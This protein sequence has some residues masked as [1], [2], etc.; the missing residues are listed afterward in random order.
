MKASIRMRIF[1]PV[2]LIL[3]AFPLAVWTM[4]RYTLD[5]HMNYNAKRDLEVAISR[6][7]KVINE[8]YLAAAAAKAI[9]TEGDTERILSLLQ[10][11]VQMEGTETRMMAV[12]GGYRV[13]H[14]VSFDGSPEMTEI[15]SLFLT[16]STGTEEFWEQGRIQEESMGDGKYLLYYRRYQLH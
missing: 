10:S 6:V 14:P 12:S 4:F 15:Y 13:L 1:L 11:E 3:I 2:T 9:G 7:E 8:N 16:K 5:V